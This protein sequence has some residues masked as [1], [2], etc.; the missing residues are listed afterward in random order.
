[1]SK[2]PAQ[3]ESI[4]DKIQAA[5]DEAKKTGT[6]RRLRI[7]KKAFLEENPEAA[8]DP[9]I[10]M[11][12]DTMVIDFE[13]NEETTAGELRLLCRANM[14]HPLAR[15]KIMSVSRLPDDHPIVVLKNDLESIRSGKAIVS[16]SPG[17]ELPT[18]FE[19][20]SKSMN[21][22]LSPDAAKKVEGEMVTNEDG[23][24]TIRT[25]LDT[26]AKTLPTN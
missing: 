10:A 18:T 12:G 22:P 6:R 3:P 4:N 16:V 25:K 14:N 13:R 26:S 9:R 5:Y 8:D 1:M 24:E 23:T 11:T 2:Q 17:I 21:L 7:D 19:S 15:M 20:K